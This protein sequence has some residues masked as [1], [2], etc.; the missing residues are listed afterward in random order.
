MKHIIGFLL[1]SFLA[2]VGVSSTAQAKYGGTTQ[3]VVENIIT[4]TS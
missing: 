4:A 1:I 3:V 2:G